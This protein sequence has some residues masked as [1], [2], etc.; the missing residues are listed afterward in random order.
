M[1]TTNSKL[2]VNSSSTE[3]LCVRCPWLWDNL[4]G[5]LCIATGGQFSCKSVTVAGNFCLEISA[6]IWVTVG[7]KGTF[8]PFATLSSYLMF[9]PGHPALN[10]CHLCSKWKSQIRNLEK[11]EE[12]CVQM[13]TTRAS[14]FECTFAEERQ[15]G[16]IRN[17][18]WMTEIRIPCNGVGCRQKRTLPRA[19]EHIYIP[20]QTHTTIPRRRLHEQWM[21]G[22]SITLHNV[23]GQAKI[24]SHC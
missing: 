5:T 12:P 9:E 1:I 13:H 11:T 7:W 4:G 16:V 22:N 24:A 15:L 23:S 14:L 19:T 18:K 6:L 17:S 20:L 21:E 3:S 10:E 2:K 8:Q